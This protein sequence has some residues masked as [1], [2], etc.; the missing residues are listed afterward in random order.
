MPCDSSYMEPTA[1]ELQII[2]TARLLVHV[3]RSTGQNVPSGIE[4]IAENRQG[5]IGR[6]AGDNIVA[7]M[8]E[9]MHGLTPEQVEELAYKPRNKTARA[10]ADW[11]EEHQ[12]A[13]KAREAIEAK[14]KLDRGYLFPKSS[15]VPK[16]KKDQ[17]MAWY[18]KLGSTGQGYVNMLLLLRD[19]RKPVKAKD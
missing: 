12:A 5:M 9:V 10:L 7:A 13:D 4:N 17:V 15:G 3:L 6:K 16:A 14:G 8:C 1:Y 2:N 18:D 11:W 19:N